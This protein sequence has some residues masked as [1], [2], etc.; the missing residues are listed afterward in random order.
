MA[1]R[2]RDLLGSEADPDSVLSQQLAYWA[3]TL[4]DLPA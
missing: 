4:D 2:Q 3:K 1:G